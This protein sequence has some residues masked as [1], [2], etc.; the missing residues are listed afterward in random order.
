MDATQAPTIKTFR[1]FTIGR[2]GRRVVRTG[3]GTFGVEL[4]WSNG[5]V[6]PLSR[7]FPARIGAILYAGQAIEAARAGGMTHV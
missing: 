7:T 1:L 6:T 5:A 2:S 4:I 3:G